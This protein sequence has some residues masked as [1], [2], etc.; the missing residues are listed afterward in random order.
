MPSSTN[1]HAVA[2]ISDELN[3]ICG[4]KGWGSV[5]SARPCH[6]ATT[7]N[8]NRP[9]LSISLP[10]VKLYHAQLMMQLLYTGR[11]NMDGGEEDHQG[12]LDLLE[13]LDIKINPA[14]L[15]KE[16]IRGRK[17]ARKSLSTTPETSAPTIEETPTMGM[18]YVT[19]F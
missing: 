14:S 6:G 9:P 17:Q 8:P 13:R 7:N 5:P 18:Y 19:S 12:L 1:F 11:V 16:Q 15:S 10:E 3:A 2:K 4:C